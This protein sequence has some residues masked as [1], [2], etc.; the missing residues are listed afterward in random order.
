MSLV[1]VKELYLCTWEGERERERDSTLA[2]KSTQGIQLQ[3]I[4]FLDLSGY[5]PTIT[6]GS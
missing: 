1:G 3:L 2:S 6:E 5:S 4:S